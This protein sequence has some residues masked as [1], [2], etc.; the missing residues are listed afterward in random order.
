[1]DLP[2]RQQ[3]PLTR[4]EQLVDAG[5]GSSSQQQV[6]RWETNCKILLARLPEG[7]A[8]SGHSFVFGFTAKQSALA[9]GIVL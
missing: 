6:P 1:M 7:D 2:S 8:T 9:A 3:S 5:R 4:D